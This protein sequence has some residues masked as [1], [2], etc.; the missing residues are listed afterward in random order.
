VN[1]NGKGNYTNNSFDSEIDLNNNFKVQDRDN[2]KVQDNNIYSNDEYMKQMKQCQENLQ[3]MVRELSGSKIKIIFSLIRNCYEFLKT[4][5]ESLEEEK[6]LTEEF[7]DKNFKD[8]NNVV[9]NFLESDISN[10]INN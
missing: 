5:E 2:I 8:L 10:N 4:L 1:T 6:Q 7:I 9:K 3:E